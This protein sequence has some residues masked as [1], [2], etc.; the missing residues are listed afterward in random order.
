MRGERDANAKHLAALHAS[1][2]VVQCAGCGVSVRWR[3]LEELY[4]IGWSYQLHT[5]LRLRWTCPSCQRSTVAQ[6]VAL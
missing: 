3:P 6:G 5:V 1:A 4:F 2:R